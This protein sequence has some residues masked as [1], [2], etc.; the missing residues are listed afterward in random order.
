MD[1]F[2]DYR[3]PFQLVTVEAF[4]LMK[5]QLNEDGILLINIVGSTHSKYTG[6]IHKTLKHVFP[7]CIIFAA[8]KDTSKLQNLI[9][10]AC[11][12]RPVLNSDSLEKTIHSL[13]Q[14][15]YLMPANQYSIILQDNF[16]PV[17]YYL[18]Q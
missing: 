11:K 1:A 9:A 8:E 15:A 14:K 12:T 3:I 18:K 2:Q 4:T 7:K 5:K 17:E 10:F 6:S 13:F 16:A